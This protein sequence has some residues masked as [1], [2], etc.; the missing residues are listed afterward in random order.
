MNWYIILDVVNNEFNK[1]LANIVF[2]ED[3]P[4]F[5]AAMKVGHLLNRQNTYAI[6]ISMRHEE[7][8]W[9]IKK[10]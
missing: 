4:N 7:W 6:I 1:W 3:A 10:E 9:D 2:L 8:H 5:V